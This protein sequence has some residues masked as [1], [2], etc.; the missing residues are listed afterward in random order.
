L[1][2]DEFANPL[3]LRLL[4]EAL[5]AFGVQ[6]AP[7]GR[8]GIRSIINLL[9]GAKNQKAAAV[10]DYDARE[11][12]VS[13]AMLRLAGAMAEAGTTQLPLSK[14]KELVDGSPAP[15]SRSLFAVLEEESLIA[16]VERPAIT[17]GGEPAYSVRFTFERVGDHL[18]VE[19]LLSG[20]HDIKRA[21][22]AGR[23][24]HFLSESDASARAN[25]G[26][27]EALSIQLPET[28]GVELIDA[29]DGI[30]P[31]LLQESFI[32]GLQWRNPAHISDQTRRL[33]RE[34]LSNGDIAALAFEAILGLAARPNHPLNAGFLDR[35]LGPIPMLTRDPLWADM[36]E[37]SYSGW[38]ERV[39]PRSGV[40]RLI[41]TARRADL[42]ALPDE[43]G[44]LWGVALAWF[45]ASPDRRIRDRATMALVSLFRARSAVL[46]SLLGRFTESD[47]EYIAE[48]VLVAS[49]GALLLH[50]SKPH[51]H[52]AASE[53]Y[54]RYFIKGEPPLNASLRDHARLI[55]E[56]AVELNV[57][58]PQLGPDRYRPPYT[59]PWP[60][61]LPSEQG[62]TSFAEDRKRFP[63]MSLVELFGLATGTDFARYIVEPYVVNPFN[64]EDAGLSKLGLFRWFLKRAVDLGYPGPKD[65]SALFDRNLLATFGGGRGKPGWAERLGKKYYWIFLRQLVGQVADHAGRKD[66]F[67]EKS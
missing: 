17:L 20:V 8:E 24:L 12:R 33:V 67:S 50:P 22:T 15:Q 35:L 53:I 4:C 31:I 47:D 52:D 9:S 40:H 57:P 58:P 43:V 41:D 42:S 45:C 37:T 26:L 11:N 61:Q 3:F 18:I 54:D 19:H 13:A 44:T 39:N 64:V 25:A 23:E 1:L 32:A 2:Q 6:A 14:A 38:S 16:V 66:W 27:L 30:A 28:H 51:L 63:Q 60:I 62:V 65:H 48:R 36:L 29:A 10:C 46:V 7:A 49:Y 34:A 56:L 5:R 59:S 21:F 55:I